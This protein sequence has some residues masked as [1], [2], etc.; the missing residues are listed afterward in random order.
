MA[1]S[2]TTAQRQQ[3]AHADPFG[4]PPP[5]VALPESAKGPFAD[6]FVD[7]FFADD[8]DDEEEEEAEEAEVDDDDVAEPMSGELVEDTEAPGGPPL[9]SKPLGVRYDFKGEV[10]GELSVSENELVVGEYEAEGWW[11]CRRVGG[12]GGEGFVPA[13]YVVP[14]SPGARLECQFDFAGQ[15]A[16][17]LSMPNGSTAVYVE[18]GDGWVLVDAGLEKRGWV[19]LSYLSHK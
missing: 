18:A 19:P 5:T 17:E 1:A 3:P 15:D 11:F 12:A 8:D 2:A 16:T 9:A 7:D 4:A 10:A 6:D 14:L 13:A